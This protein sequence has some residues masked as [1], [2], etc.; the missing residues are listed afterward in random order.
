MLVGREI[1]DS[2]GAD[3]EAGVLL[4]R[5]LDLDPEMVFTGRPFDDYTGAPVI[6]EPHRPHRAPRAHG[7]AIQLDPNDGVRSYPN[8]VL[9][10]DLDDDRHLGR[11][12][13]PS[14][15]LHLDPHRDRRGGGKAQPT[16]QQRTQQPRFLFTHD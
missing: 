15:R 10:R 1:R 9:R 14:Q 6:L 13:D 12:A 3:P 11:G 5:I 16:G 4:I 7:A 8:P 2:Y